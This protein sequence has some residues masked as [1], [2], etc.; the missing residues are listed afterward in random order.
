M[1]GDTWCWLLVGAALLPLSAGGRAPAPIRGCR[2]WEMVGE[3]SRGQPFVAPLGEGLELYLQ[4]IASGWILRVV[5]SADSAIA[6]DYAEVA[7][8]PYRSV[9]PLS[10]STD[11]SFRAQDAVGWN[12]RKFRF[13]ADRSKYQSL[14]GLYRQL[15]T[16][17]SSASPQVQAKLALGAST[18]TPA[19]LQILDAALIPGSANQ[20]RAA[21]TVSQ[22]LSSTAHTM[23]LPRD[24]VGSPLGVLLR[25]RF[26]LVLD[27]PLAFHAGAALRPAGA[28]DVSL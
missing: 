9:T 2:Q 20:Q 5:P 12:P 26:R 23:V 24:G 13:A 28:C 22:R 18:A 4:P 7:T 25:V 3:V 10:L 27:L 6:P 17:G 15:P 16:D 19:E 21:A 8:P 14:Q 1:D 11:F